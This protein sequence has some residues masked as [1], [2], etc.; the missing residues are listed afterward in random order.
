LPDDVREPHRLVQLVAFVRIGDQHRIV[1]LH[2]DIRVW[3]DA[4]RLRL[5][6]PRNL[7]R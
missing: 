5:D 6:R 2:V 3:S 1:V 4:R 7:L